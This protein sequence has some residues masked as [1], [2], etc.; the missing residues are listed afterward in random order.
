MIRNHLP[1]H[2][3]SALASVAALLLSSVAI[4]QSSPT[5]AP[6]KDAPAAAAAQKPMSGDKPAVDT[7][8]KLTDPAAKDADRATRLK[9]QHDAERQQLTGVLHAPMTE[10]MKQDLRQH[11]E[12]VA[13]LERIRSVA[14]DAKDTATVDRAN[15]LLEKENA[16]YEKWMSGLGTKTES[17]PDLKAKAGAQ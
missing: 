14:L 17:T 16:H 7:K 5:T 2:L 13:K 11:A 8:N 9:T 4:A 3:G 15:K 1:R 6:A 10:V 12:R